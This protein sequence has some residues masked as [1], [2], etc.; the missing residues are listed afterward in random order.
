MRSRAVDNDGVAC[1]H[2]A[3]VG[4]SCAVDFEEL[5]HHYLP[6]SPILYILLL[7]FLLLVLSALLTYF[8]LLVVALKTSC[9]QMDWCLAMWTDNGFIVLNIIFSL[10]YTPGFLE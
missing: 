5:L 6:P 4:V 10:Y 2:H 8:M 9:A 7:L 1:L 3:G